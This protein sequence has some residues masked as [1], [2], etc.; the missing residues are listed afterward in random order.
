MSYTYHRYYSN[1]GDSAHGGQDPYL[2][3]LEEQIKSQFDTISK[4]KQLINE[5]TIKI[6]QLEADLD[7][8]QRSGGSSQNR[9]KS[10]VQDLERTNRS[11]ADL[12]D[13]LNDRLK[14]LQKENYQLQSDKIGLQHDLSHSSLQARGKQG[15]DPAVEE[16]IENLKYEI[17]CDQRENAELHDKIDK[18]ESKIETL[19]AEL[20]AKNQLLS[21]LNNAKTD[22]VSRDTSTSQYPE[23]SKKTSAGHQTPRQGTEESQDND[24]FKI[25]EVSQMSPKDLE[26]RA[27]KRELMK[28][29]EDNEQ[30]R[31]QLASLAKLKEALEETGSKKS[32]EDVSALIAQIKQGEK[33]RERLEEVATASGYTDLNHLL[34]HLDKVAQSCPSMERLEYFQGTI[35][36]NK[37]TGYGVDIKANGEKYSGMFKDG[38][39]HGMGH[40]ETKEFEFTGQFEAGNFD[41]NVGF[42]KRRA[43]SKSLKLHDN[44]TYDGEVE[45]DSPHGKGRWIFKDGYELEGHFVEGKFDA[46]NKGNL[47]FNDEVYEISAIDL[48]DMGITIF[49]TPDKTYTWVFNKK[50]WHIQKS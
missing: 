20:I 35:V 6:H 4:Q 37:K 22:D 2:K 45:G 24:G 26:I 31:E 47:R 12:I 23:I 7:F 3:S 30:N 16:L 39:R 17:K 25:L 28:M 9:L 15:M 44:V 49:S 36:R 43:Q 11:Q 21:Q 27:L 32:F 34:E 10:Q 42:Y 48:P 29:H 1:A 8:A 50:T 18:L 41:K 38:E 19:Q 14:R 46:N 5:Q 13:Q 33:L 40:L